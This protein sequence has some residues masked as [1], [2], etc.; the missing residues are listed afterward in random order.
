MDPAAL[1]RWIA[2]AA[3]VEPRVGGSYSYGWKYKYAERDV[4][5]G[6]TRI[7]D[8]VENERLVTDW[9]DWRGQDERGL[10][11]VA[12]MLENL[13]EKTKVTLVHG[14]FTRA[15]DLSDYPFGWGEFLGQLRKNVETGTGPSS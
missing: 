12:W 1:N 8:Y 13:G 6:P 7:L 11:R 4:I 9:T 14:G 10:T 2:S 3:V 15:A 5:G